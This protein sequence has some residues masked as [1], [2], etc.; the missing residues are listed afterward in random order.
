MNLTTTYLGKKLE[1]PLVASASPL[2]RSLDNIR[3]LEDAGASAIVLF[4]LF[5]EEIL[6]ETREL[7]HYLTYGTESYAEALSY[8]PEPEEFYLGPDEYL[9][10]IRRAKNAVSIP[11]IGSLNGVSPGG[12]INYARKIEATG[13]DAIELNLRYG[14]QLIEQ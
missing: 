14:D 9:E 13:A 7:D 4:S 11:I 5:E 12:W 10:H 6:H 2:A 3:R 1:N 8:L